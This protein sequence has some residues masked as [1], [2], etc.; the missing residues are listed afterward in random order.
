MYIFMLNN[1]F[2]FIFYFIKMYIISSIVLIFNFIFY[3]IRKI[4]NNIYIVCWK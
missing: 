3:N 4:E 1:K 2:M